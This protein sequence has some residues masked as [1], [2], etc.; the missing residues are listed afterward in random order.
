MNLY[1]IKTTPI[2]GPGTEL[3]RAIFKCTSQWVSG[4]P[5]LGGKE[6]GDYLLADCMTHFGP[7]PTHPTASG[8]SGRSCLSTRS[9]RW[10]QHLPF[11]SCSQGS[12]LDLPRGPGSQQSSLRGHSEGSVETVEKG[13]SPGPSPDKTLTVP[14]ALISPNNLFQLAPH[15]GWRPETGS[16]RWNSLRCHSSGPR[17][18]T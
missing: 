3:D 18:F 8:T 16:Q 13:G 15:I 9:G 1:N 10:A 7:V 17:F 6:G 12:H 5:T 4:L 2:S 11:C 14:L